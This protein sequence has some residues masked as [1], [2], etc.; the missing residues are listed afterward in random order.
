METTY[1][2]LIDSSEKIPFIL[3][4]GLHKELQQF[5]LEE[6]RLFKLFTDI[7]ISE[8]VIKIALSKRNERGMVISEFVEVEMVMAED[9]HTLLNLIF[10]YFSDFFLKNQQKLKTLTNSLNQISKQ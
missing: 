8:Q 3:T 9:I 7:D 6:D 4:Y 5:L 10:D 2:S 1:I